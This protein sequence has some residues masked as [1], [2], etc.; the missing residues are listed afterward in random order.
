VSTEQPIRIA[1]YAR[2]T[3]GAPIAELEGQQRA[4]TAFC[5]AT[6]TASQ[7][8]EFVSD[9]DGAVP[10]PERPGLNRLRVLVNS[11]RVD[12]IVAKSGDLMHRDRRL[13]AGFIHCFWSRG[14]H[15]LFTDTADLMKYADSE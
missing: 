13:N 6:F 10:D 7:I 4:L 8:I 5:E 12:C 11:E 3:P 1:L 2:H 15:V 14:A 9:E